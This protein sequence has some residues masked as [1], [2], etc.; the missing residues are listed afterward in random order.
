MESKRP[1]SLFASR[2]SR[3]F[4]GISGKYSEQTLGGGGKKC[5][6]Q[7]NW[8]SKAHP[9]AFPVQKAYGLSCVGSL[10]D[11]RL[12]FPDVLMSNELLTMYSTRS[13]AQ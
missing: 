1:A 5:R 8:A 4:E 6:R 7:K 11:G 9:L 3:K 13:P 10:A 12:P 2:P